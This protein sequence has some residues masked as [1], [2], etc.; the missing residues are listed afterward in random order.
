MY[1]KKINLKVFLVK[2]CVQSYFNRFLQGNVLLLQLF[3]D[4][5]DRIQSHNKF[6]H[7]INSTNVL[8]ISRYKLILKKE[9]YISSYLIT[10]HAIAKAGTFTFAYTALKKKKTNFTIKLFSHC[11]V[12]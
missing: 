1:L 3:V 7:Y 11:V 2:R 12:W 6:T 9:K 4:S 8:T 5:V 10:F